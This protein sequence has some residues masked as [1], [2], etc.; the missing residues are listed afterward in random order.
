M[1]IKEGLAPNIESGIMESSSVKPSLPRSVEHPGA[2]EFEL[3]PQ[4]GSRGSNELLNFQEWTI[5]STMVAKETVQLAS[6]HPSS[7]T[8]TRA[9]QALSIAG[10]QEEAEE[11]AR[12]A[13]KHIRTDWLSQRRFDLASTLAAIRVLR[14]TQEGDPAE[15]L[16]IDLPTHPL[17]DIARA[18]HLIAQDELDTA[19]DLLRDNTSSEAPGLR[20]YILLS[21]GEYQAALRELRFAKKLLPADPDITINTALAYWKL[22]SFRRAINSAREASR[23]AP[24]RKDISLA[25]LKYLL[26]AG[27]VHEASLEVRSILDRNVVE[28]C[29]FLFMQAQIA[30]AAD[31][32][33]KAEALLKRAAMR[34]RSE[35]DV[36]S[37]VEAT[38]NLAVLKAAKGDIKHETVLTEIRKSLSRDP[39]NVA[40]VSMLA[41]WST[42]VSDGVEVRRYYDG[43]TASPADTYWA[44]LSTKLAYL[45]C[46]WEEAL[47]W[48]LRWGKEEPLDSRVHAF[49]VMLMGQ[50]R[51]NWNQAAKMALRS[52]ES[53]E[54]TVL[55]RNNCAYALALAGNAEH[56]RLVLGEVDQSSYLLTATLGLV[57]M[58][59][60][61]V[62]QGMAHYRRAAELADREP[63]GNTVRSLMTCHQVLALRRLN[64]LDEKILCEI[65]AGALPAVDLPDDWTDRPEFRLLESVAKRHDWPWPSVIV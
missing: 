44:E 32:K 53:V 57:E 35:G 6:D 37:E 48:S 16:L 14:T 9:A 49:S 18:R 7:V 25:L 63:D 4:R 34:A 51:D 3:Q 58:A 22:R 10:M 65:M 61:R 11:A 55:L 60:G 64:L 28:V 24:G 21:R 40:L 12:Q 39:C 50:A 46:R 13:L 59:R 62:S 5:Q 17:L 43:L 41:D 38:A 27:R 29:D 31:Q 54:V 36:Q 47:E 8:Y 52:L 23:I 56:A 15:S 19:L 42:H 33:T 1:L 2:D 20:A 30:V 45:E 26:Q